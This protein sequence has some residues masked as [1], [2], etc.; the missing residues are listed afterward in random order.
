MKS[1]RFLAVLSP[2]YVNSEYCRAEF[3]AALMR[4][5]LNKTARIVIVR[6]T[7]SDV[8]ELWAPISRIE[9]VETGSHIRELFLK[10]VRALP[11]VK[12]LRKTKPK[13]AA[14]ASPLPFAPSNASVTASGDRSIAAGRD[15]N[16]YAQSR[17]PRGRAKPPADVISEEQGVKLKKLIDEVIELDSASFGRS[18][19]EAQLQKKWWGALAKEVPNTTYTNYSQR[20]FNKAMNW[21]RKHR[22]RLISGVAEDEPEL[23]RAAHIRAIHAY[24]TRNKI[25][26]L[27]YYAELS[28][29]LGISPAFQSSKNLSDYDLGRVYQA[30]RR[31]SKKR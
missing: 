8:P 9:L 29:R 14:P 6:I 31:D 3:G 20:R 1:Q 26:K 10:G 27:S 23:S 30:T 19:S 4:D 2:N 7:P 25:N 22:G 24:I 28:E 18:L 15:V 5:P 16:F 13:P 21:L 12:P 11:P 17:R